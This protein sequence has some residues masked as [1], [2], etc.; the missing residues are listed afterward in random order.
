MSS[1][2]DF[3]KKSK[4]SISDL[5]K[6]L[7]SLDGKKDYKDDRLWRPEPDKSGNGYAV[8]RFLP[9][10]K[11]EE[12][13]FV[14]M[15]SHAFQGKGGW[16][17]ENCLTTNGGKCPVC[18]LNNEL[19]N[20]G[21]E[22]DKNIARERKRK[23]TYIS[24]ILVVKDEAN[25]QNEGKVFLFKYGVKIFDK[26]KEAMY[27]EFKDEQAID[28]FNF[29]SGA[30]FKLKIRKVAGYT[31][32]DK[33]EFAA[34]SPLFGGD[35]AKL[36]ALWNKQYSLQDFV[37]PKNFKEYSALKSRLYEI[38]GDDIRSTL[39]ENTSRAEDESEEPNPFD[40]PSR[41]KPSPKKQEP[42]PTDEPGEEMDSLSY[43][44]KLA[45]E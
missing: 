9:A 25:P 44:Q 20:S 29:W 18:E 33:S 12:L 22:T 36:E 23:L 7:E 17:I 3:K 4:S 37:A 45:E 15:Y 27:P 32:Y 16:F 11:N 38:L 34:S 21:I 13:P 28:P 35:D 41:T 14:K 30:D 2:N 39:M 40:A 31:N 19:W 5:T 24:N 26:I 6:A 43:F 42:A 10:P 1:F 8:I